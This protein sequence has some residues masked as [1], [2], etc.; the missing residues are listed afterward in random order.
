MY[1]MLLMLLFLC[2]YCYSKFPMSQSKNFGWDLSY[3]TVAEIR[4]AMNSGDLSP[5]T[6]AEIHEALGKGTSALLDGALSIRDTN[7]ALSYSAWRD[8]SEKDVWKY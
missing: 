3:F 8:D 5:A 2:C 1:A 6:V 7:A 4:E